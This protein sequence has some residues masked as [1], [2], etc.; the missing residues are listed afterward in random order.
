MNETTTLTRLYFTAFRRWWGLLVAAMVCAVVPG[1]LY[2]SNTD[3]IYETQI[4]TLIQN[5]GLSVDAKA[6]HNKDRD[7]LSTQSEII[8]SPLVIRRSFDILPP[9][10]TLEIDVDPVVHVTKKLF[11][12]P[13]VSTD[14][15]RLS[16]RDSDPERS[17]GRLRAIIESYQQYLQE[18]EQGNSDETVELLEKQELTLKRQRE[19]LE[20]SLAQIREES[21][22]IGEPRDSVRTETATLREL[23]NRLILLSSKRARLESVLNSQEQ[24]TSAQSVV[25]LQIDEINV[26]TSRMLR[27]LHNN[28]SQAESEVQK[29]SRVFGPLHPERKQVEDQADALRSQYS[30]ALSQAADAMKKQLEIARSE[31]AHIQKLHDTE[32]Q[33]LSTLDAFLLRE[34]KLK[35]ELQR[36]NQTHESTVAQLRQK[37]LNKE[38]LAG[39]QVSII[40]RVLDEYVIPQK[41][42]WPQPIPLLMACG[43]LGL[44]MGLVVMVF[45][46]KLP[47]P[48]TQSFDSLVSETSES[49]RFMSDRIP[50]SEMNSSETNIQQQ[51]KPSQDQ[52]TS[53][54]EPQ[55][56]LANA[57]PAGGT[58]LR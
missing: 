41:P 16:Y 55:Q 10:P 44:L 46:E 49:S 37:Q 34:E 30:H 13:L 43:L 19:S 3:A 31:E 38:A 54:K 1:V 11:V 33:R 45:V 50:V 12:S 24:T 7:F 32:R 17:A 8:R 23:A 35:S 26:E 20:T 42:V 51:E 40:V 4:R 21:P 18:I 58:L 29:L 2:L 48:G 53:K 14:I 6:T 9:A 39:G 28:L 36:I 22:F 27:D 5:N 47:L 25:P 52:L 57:G 15:V 56:A